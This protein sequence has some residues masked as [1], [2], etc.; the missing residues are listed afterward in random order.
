MDL[1]LTNHARRGRS[2]ELISFPVE[3]LLHATENTFFLYQN[4]VMHRHQLKFTILL[5]TFRTQSSFLVLPQRCI[6][7]L[8]IF[9]SVRRKPRNEQWDNAIDVVRFNILRHSRIKPIATQ[10]REIKTAFRYLM[11]LR[12]HEQV[13]YALRYCHPPPKLTARSSA[14][15]TT[16]KPYISSVL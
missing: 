16:R 7:P 2:L 15:N 6:S 14:A 11:A 12:K 4:R 5:H 1:K 10:F 3:N 8:S 9:Y 13:G